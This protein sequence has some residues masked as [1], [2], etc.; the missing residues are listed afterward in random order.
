MN[1]RVLALM[2]ALAAAIV[3]IVR[4]ATPDSAKPA[5]VSAEPARTAV[6]SVPTP[7]A[8]VND[9]TTAA[10]ATPSNASAATDPHTHDPNV[11]DDDS[12]RDA[13]P[14]PTGRTGGAGDPTSVATAFAEAWTR[15]R[16]PDAGT[17]T[18]RVSALSTPSL[19]GKL[20][21]VDPAVVPAD[22]VTGPA[23]VTATTG[24]ADA[25]VPTNAGTLRLTLIYTGKWH[26]NT[27]DWQRAPR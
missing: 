25:A 7:A 13:E 5:D 23:L 16:G 3:I 24:W 4:L 19:A 14:G 21:D 12:A 11:I 17:W 27:L 1:R 18:E 9:P 6:T 15:H 26:V 20:R 2:V 22:T 10:V 8:A